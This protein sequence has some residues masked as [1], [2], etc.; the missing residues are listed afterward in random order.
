MECKWN[1]AHFVQQDSG[2]FELFL[3]QNEPLVD[4]CTLTLVLDP[5]SIVEP[6]GQDINTLLY[7]LYYSIPILK[8]TLLH[9]IFCAHATSQL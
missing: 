1:V 9:P 4:P 3:N 7:C 2:T 5:S 8:D 6:V